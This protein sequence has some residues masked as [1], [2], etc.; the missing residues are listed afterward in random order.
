MAMRP[1]EDQEAGGLFSG[2]FDRGGYVTRLKELNAA[3]ERIFM[4]NKLLL[5]VDEQLNG[6]RLALGAYRRGEVESARRLA[7]GAS[8]SGSKLAKERPRSDAGL[9]GSGVEDSSR[10]SDCALVGT[11]FLYC[12]PTVLPTFLTQFAAKL[13]ARRATYRSQ[14][15][16][17]VRALLAMNPSATELSE[18]ECRLLLAESGLPEDSLKGVD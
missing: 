18:R 10:H 16:A 13:E 17:A 14:R 5:I 15:K 4:Y 6:V 8:S 2:I 7:A 9:P 1:R 12:S 11:T 3:A